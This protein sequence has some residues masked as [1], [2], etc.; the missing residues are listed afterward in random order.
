MVTQLT[1]ILSYIIISHVIIIIK[2]VIRIISYMDDKY[3]M[4]I[5][6]KAI[7]G[8]VKAVLFL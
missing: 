4:P 3:S 6:H 8:K 5:W 2:N 7:K 1:V